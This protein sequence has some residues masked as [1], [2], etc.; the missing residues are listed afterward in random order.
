MG[1][2]SGFPEDSALF[3]R[4]TTMRRR[5][6]AGKIVRLCVY[7][8]KANRTNSGSDNNRKNIFVRENQLERIVQGIM[9]NANYAEIIRLPKTVLHA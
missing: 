7:L 6:N 1:H 4:S 2:L 5:E 8:G 9:S 3:T